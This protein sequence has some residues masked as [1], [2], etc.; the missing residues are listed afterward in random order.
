MEH[1]EEKEGFCTACSVPIPSAFVDDGNGIE[2]DNIRIIRKTG[3]N[4][5]NIIMILLLIVA[6]VYISSSSSDKK[7]K[8]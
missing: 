7:K 4:Y 3:F 2:I 5:N 8:K 6:L 1:E